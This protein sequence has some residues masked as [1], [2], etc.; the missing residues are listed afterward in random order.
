MTYHVKRNFFRFP[1]NSASNYK[2][3]LCQLGDLALVEVHQLNPDQRFLI[4]Q[5]WNE[6]DLQNVGIDNLKKILNALSKDLLYEQY[7]HAVQYRSKGHDQQ[8]KVI[9]TLHTFKDQ[10]DRKTKKYL[11]PPGDT[12]PSLAIGITAILSSFSLAFSAPNGMLP[13]GRIWAYL[14]MGAGALFNSV[15]VTGFPGLERTSKD[16][17]FLIA[18]LLSA[19]PPATLTFFGTKSTVDSYVFSIF[20][21][22][23]NLLLSG[24]WGTISFKCLLET[25]R[26]LRTYYATTK[27]AQAFSIGVAVFLA[28]AISAS[29]CGPVRDFMAEEMGVKDEITMWLVALGFNLLEASLF[30]MS[31]LETQMKIRTRVSKALEKYSSSANSDLI[32]LNNSGENNHH[33]LSCIT[34]ENFLWFVSEMVALCFTVS[35]FAQF[36]SLGKQTYDSFMTSFDFDTFAESYVSQVISAV[37]SV[38][39]GIAAGALLINA[40]PTIEKII[41]GTPSMIFQI[42]RGCLSLAY[43]FGRKAKQA[44][45]YC[46]PS[47]F[48]PSLETEVLLPIAEIPYQHSLQLINLENM[49]SQLYY[50]LASEDVRKK[51]IEAKSDFQGL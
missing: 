3:R 25:I 13:Y 49:P 36:Q 6:I 29:R 19:V 46:F 17:L 40:G 45:S 35:Y 4:G 22:S 2:F 42:P 50:L 44:A 27:I 24:G 28:S 5:D 21:S 32:A 12:M 8:R 9:N 41:L 23:A 30:M 26:T 10:A 34:K 11:I 51:I 31:Y 20:T 33:A 47:Y 18:G 15:G 14:S 43:W 1:E 39:S 38:S 7:T 16:V 48:T 37:F